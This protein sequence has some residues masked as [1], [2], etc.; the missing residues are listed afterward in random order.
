MKGLELS[1]VSTY[2]LLG[3]IMCQRSKLPCFH[4]PCSFPPGPWPPTC[5]M[6][7]EIAYNVGSGMLH[8][9]DVFVSKWPDNAE[10]V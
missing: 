4:R 9:A 7:T 1:L 5:I 8:P 6:G 2:L 3:S 10:Q